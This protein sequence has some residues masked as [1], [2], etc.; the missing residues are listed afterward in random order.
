MDLLGAGSKGGVYRAI[1]NLDGAGNSGNRT[2]TVGLKTEECKYSQNGK[3][4]DDR[5]SCIHR[6]AQTHEDDN[7]MWKE[8][9]GAFLFIATRKAGIDLPSLIPTWGM[10][11]DEQ[12][13]PTIV[14][15]NISYPHIVGM[16]M[17]IR[18]LITIKDVADQN[19]IDIAPKTPL[20]LARMMLPTAETFLFMERLGMSSQH[21]GRHNMGVPP[22]GSQ[23][24]SAFVY[25]NSYLS[26][27][28]GT[29]CSLDMNQSN[30][31]NICDKKSL[32]HEHRNSERVHKRDSDRV[33]KKEW[34]SDIIWTRD[35]YLFGKNVKALLN[36]IVPHEEDAQ[37]LQLLR[38][39]FP[40]KD[41]RMTDVVLFLRNFTRDGRR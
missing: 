2:C 32:T 8:F 30:V 21:I 11:V 27:L 35:C 25:D 18:E 29:R 15:E 17:P 3:G 31:C 6:N 14:G 9:M 7:M 24:N 23:Y 19:L 26:F 28:N 12:Q 38:D 13:P 41:C 10:V 16:V 40:N 1:L 36:V 34:T 33:H 22:P 4:K 37:S 39:Y 20:G 5:I